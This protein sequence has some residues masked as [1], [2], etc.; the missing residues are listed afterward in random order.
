MNFAQLDIRIERIYDKPHGDRSFRILVDKLWP[1]GLSKDKVSIDLWQRDIG[2]SNS[3]RKWFAHDGNKWS[4]FKNHYF[5]ELD[6][7]KA[8]VGMILDRA[9][10]Q[11]ITLLY[12]A[13]EQRFN[14]AV[15][16]KEYLEKKIK[17]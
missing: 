3:L 8:S 2:P 12:G 4:K 13:R 1:R 7:N 10:E 14:N 16:L 5:K 15:A 6:N 11:P 9:K 17:E